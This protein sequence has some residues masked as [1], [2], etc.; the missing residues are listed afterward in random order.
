VVGIWKGGYIVSDEVDEEVLDEL[1][2]VA[3]EISVVGGSYRK[4]SRGLDRFIKGIKMRT[5]PDKEFI[6]VCF[7]TL[8][9]DDMVL[10]REVMEDLTE[11]APYM[12]DY[13]RKLIALG[14]VSILRSNEISIELLKR[15]MSGE[16][17]GEN[18]DKMLKFLDIMQRK[19]FA[20]LRHVRATASRESRGKSLLDGL[21]ESEDIEKIRIE[22]F[23][24]GGSE[25]SGRDEV[26]DAEW[27]EVSEDE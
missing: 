7:R 22:V 23:K 1:D 15:F 27:S 19:E 26:E 17:L 10:V 12:S 9:S 14:T 13:E 6:D 5:P 4:R 3:L 16:D 2:S 11:N 21:L 18:E 8:G 24:K 25:A 20:Y